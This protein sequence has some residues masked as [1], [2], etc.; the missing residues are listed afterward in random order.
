[1]AGLIEWW[2]S[3]P[4]YDDPAKHGWGFALFKIV[5]NPLMWFML[6]LFLIWG[7]F[8]WLPRSI[9]NLFKGDVDDY[10]GG[11]ADQGSRVDDPAIG[12][13]VVSEVYIPTGTRRGR[14]EGE[15]WD[16]RDIPVGAEHARPEGEW[17]DLDGAVA[18]PEVREP[19]VIDEDKIKIGGVLLVVFLMLF[20]LIGASFYAFI[21]SL[22]FTAVFYSL[23]HQASVPDSEDYRRGWGPTSLIGYSVGFVAV[24][25]GLL[26]MGENPVDA[27][28]YAILV[29][30]MAYVADS[31][32]WVPHRWWGI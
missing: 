3:R 23:F 18:P 4:F 20:I 29:V 15:W 24:F 25:V 16:L 17:W 28:P 5:M 32:G 27:L 12:Y 30:L 19:W 21:L 22:F 26:A 6:P 13:E 7:V 14:P 2:M 11:I 1:M 10:Q 9:W 31:F 8:I